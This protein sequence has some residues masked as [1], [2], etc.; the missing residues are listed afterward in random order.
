LLTKTDCLNK[1]ERLTLA[2]EAKILPG[3]S[4]AYRLG[5][6]LLK[7]ICAGMYLAK[8]VS[9]AMSADAY[10]HGCSSV[11]MQKNAFAQQGWKPV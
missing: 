10:G 8:W 7:N 3:V 2:K 1:N 4:L 5:L 6:S 9:L 11:S